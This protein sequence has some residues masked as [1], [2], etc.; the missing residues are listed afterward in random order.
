MADNILKGI[1]QLEAKGVSQT[2]S[3]VNASVSKMERGLKKIPN[4]SNQATFALT[5]LSR[6]AQ[7]APYG[8]IGISNNL[9]PLLE[10]FQRLRATTGSNVSA[11]KELGKSLAGAGGIGL[12]LGI[13]SSLAV[14]FGD[15]LFGVNKAAKEA[16]SSADQL[17]ESIKGIFQNAA[18]EAAEV[19]SLIQVLKSETET[20]ERKLAAIKELQSIQ[21]D[22]FNNLRLEGNAVS[23]L[24]ASYKKYLDNLKTVIAV[25]IKQA[26]LEQLITKQ[27]KLQGITQTKSTQGLFKALDDFNNKRLQIA[28]QKGGSTNAAIIQSILG[29]RDKRQRELDQLQKDIDAALKEIG[30][31]SVGI[32]LKIGNKGGNKV[33]GALLKD[34]KERVR[35]LGP[36]ELPSV[37]DIKEPRSLSRTQAGI[38][39]IS[40]KINEDIT[41]GL[42]FKLPK[43]DVKSKELNNIIE[44]MKILGQVS[45][46]VG[47]IFSNAFGSLFNSLVTGKNAIKAFGD[48]FVQALSQ[49][50]QKLISTAILSLIVSA[51]GGGLGIGAASNKFGDIFKFLSFGGFRAAGGPVTGGKAY[52]VGE[53]GPEIFRPGTSGTIIPNNQI[54]SFGGSSI[55]GGGEYTLRIRGTDL[56]AAI[57]ATGRANV[58]LS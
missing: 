30:E 56:V 12:A 57:A 11:L 27:L 15:R 41:G 33:D 2:T 25:K 58:R 49:V 9:N 42:K 46:E 54:S 4:A 13:A 55:G 32:E 38:K 7:D 50:I 14:V 36:I 19:G 26:Q 21:P 5:N 52:V 39:R 45:L 8:F 23:G 10:S 18:K 40:D 24:D 16:K 43:F 6:V 29:P 53:K 22:V 28:K 20:R 34:V 47:G 51:F 44:N 37:F 17:R 48:A 31:L 35:N 3:A 1:I